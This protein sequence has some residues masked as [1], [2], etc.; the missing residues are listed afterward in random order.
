MKY[1]DISDL[2]PAARARYD[3][4]IHCPLIRQMTILSIVCRNQGIA[5]DQ[6]SGFHTD[7]VRVMD[8]LRAVVA[9]GSCPDEVDRDPATL[10]YS[11]VK[12]TFPP[13]P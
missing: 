9:Q 4:V 11:P 5:D 13:A 7:P 10:A 6:C 12:I 8:R 3:E 1:V 2:T